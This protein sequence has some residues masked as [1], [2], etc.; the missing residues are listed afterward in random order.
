MAIERL[1]RQFFYNQIP[2]PD[3]DPSISAK[4]VCEFYSDTYPELAQALIEGPELTEEGEVYTFRKAVGNKGARIITVADLAAGHVPFPAA[5]FP[6]ID[7][8]LMTKV[9][10]ATR[11]K[12]ECMILPPSS[13][14]GLI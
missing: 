3:P 6:K 11:I 4:E 5:D 7:F 10:Q 13:S 14:I 9:A 8:P 2:L 1:E 12:G